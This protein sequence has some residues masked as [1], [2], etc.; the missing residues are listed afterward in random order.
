MDNG[1]ISLVS[2]NYDKKVNYGGKMPYGVNDN[3]AYGFVWKTVERL[4]L[5]TA[6]NPLQSIIKPGNTVLVKPNLIGHIPGTYTRPEVIMP[7]IDM[8]LAAGAGKIYIADA[9]INFFETE[10]TLASTHY[11]EMARFLQGENPSIQIEAVNLNRIPRWRWV[12]LG[13]DSSF[14]NSGYRDDEVGFD[15]G[16]SLLNHKYYLT[17]DWLGKSP[18]GKPLGWYAISDIVL[19][20]DVVINMPKM[21]THW[22]MIVTL[23]LKN[24]VGCTMASTYD[25]G[26]SGTLNMARIPHCHVKDTNYFENDVSARVLQDLNKIIL[27]CDKNGQLKNS[28]QRKYLTVIDGIEAMEK[29]QTSL[30]G[31]KG[32]R[33]MSRLVLAGEDPV[34]TDMVACRA[35]GYDYRHIPTLKKGTMD[36]IHRIGNYNQDNIVIIG[37]NLDTR[38]NH[39]FRFNDCWKKD[40]KLLAIRKFSPPKIRTLAREGNK[41]IA[42]IDNCT[43]A[44]LMYDERNVL[45]MSKNDNPYFAELPLSATNIYIFAH[46]KYLNSI[47]KICDFAANP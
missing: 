47:S 19:D 30:Y 43:A 2:F 22:T 40:A 44:H 42:S 5:G 17:A 20:A 35:M 21:K 24:L 11:S 32:K 16:Q 27:Y 45:T 29:S 7:I 15:Y 8:A 4:G 36:N 46:D 38:I 6:K 31:A 37:E 1:D 33:R 39:V 41:V 25:H 10:H 23:S 18:N 28:R 3:P 13:E 9:G 26:A 34:S 14:Y 12:S